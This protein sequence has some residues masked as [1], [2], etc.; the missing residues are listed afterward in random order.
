MAFNEGLLQVGDRAGY[1][2][3]K[4]RKELLISER[5]TK[6]LLLREFRR[7]KRDKRYQFKDRA[8]KAARR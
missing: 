1:S 3:V 6:G 8:N 4:S 5:L 2:Q 7:G